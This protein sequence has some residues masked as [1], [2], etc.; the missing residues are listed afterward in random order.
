MKR[1]VLFL[2]LSVLVIN[3]SG[4]PVELWNGK[5]CAV[6]FTYDDGLN[7]HLDNAIPLLDSLG[8]SGTFYI[9]GN[10]Q[11][12]AERLHE[13]R[14]AAQRGHELGNHTL[15]HPC[16]GN[17]PGREWVSNDH[18]LSNY[19]LQQIVDE[20]KVANTLLKAV[21]GRN[22]RTFAYTCGDTEVE[23]ELFY[24]RLRD[25]FVAAR[26][27]TAAMNDV[28]TMNP[29]NMNSFMI[30]GENGEQLIDLVKKA[31]ETG[32]LL[33]FLFHGVGGEHDLNVSLA[34]HRKL[35]RYVKENEDKIW[36]GALAEAALHIADV[37]GK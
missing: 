24:P 15:F 27:V 21:D 20:I 5:K 29:E 31:S 14:R 7:V 30:H 25:E 34:A 33:V 19:T 4:Q 10:S 23:G 1:S 11:S 2:L 37:Q 8:L 9:P 32:S 16:V 17:K 6:V 22:V 36:T 3:V 13:W 18:D 12:F 28:K 26:G 35:L